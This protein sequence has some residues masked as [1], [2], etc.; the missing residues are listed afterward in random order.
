M[1]L[2]DKNTIKVDLIAFKKMLSEIEY[3]VSGIIETARSGDDGYLRSMESQQLEIKSLVAGFMLPLEPKPLTPEIIDNG[4][5]YMSK[6][7]D[8]VLEEDSNK[9]G[10][11]DSMLLFQHRL[12]NHIKRCIAKDD[13]LS[14]VKNVDLINYIEV[15]YISN[16]AEFKKLTIDIF[17]NA[18]FKVMVDVNED[19][20]TFRKKHSQLNMF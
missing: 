3:Y 20:Q 12:Y 16:H 11:R 6:L 4:K 9:R 17:P 5:P 18:A 19:I 8:A 1:S 2:K 10:K 15:E 7:V 13:K 14:E